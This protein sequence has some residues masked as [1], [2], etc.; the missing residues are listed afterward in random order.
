M[1]L[2]TWKLFLDHP[3]YD[4]VWSSRAVENH[5]TRVTVPTLSV[6]GYYDQEDMWG[7][8]GGVRQAWSRTTPNTRISS[9]SAPGVMARGLRLRATSAI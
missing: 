3:A 1:P 8:A 4:T 2:P 7:P 6:G 5:L 9:S